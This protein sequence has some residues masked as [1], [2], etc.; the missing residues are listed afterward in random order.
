M[1][2]LVIKSK[3]CGTHTVLYDDED[4][5][6]IQSFKWRLCRVKKGL[7]GPIV[8]GWNKSKRQNI[9]IHRAIMNPPKELCVDHI[10][11]NRLDNRRCNLRLATIA[12]NNRNIWRHRKNTTGY[13]GVSFRKNSARNPWEARISVDG[14]NVHIGNYPTKEQ[15][16]L[17]YNEAA[18]KYYGDFA[19]LNKVE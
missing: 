9:A 10:N 7:Y 15:A 3:L 5:H 12:E 17:A 4:E 18:K 19:R 1:G 8:V 13:K 16:A 11:L 2:E 14:K 6:I